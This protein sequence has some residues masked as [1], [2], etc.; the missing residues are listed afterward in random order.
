MVFN[1]KCPQIYLSDKDNRLVIIILST[2]TCINF[3][4]HFKGLILEL[5]E[6]KTIT[7]N[8]GVHVKMVDITGFSNDWFY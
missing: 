4:C 7:I 6:M 3:Y 1:F 2:L 8:F 5:F